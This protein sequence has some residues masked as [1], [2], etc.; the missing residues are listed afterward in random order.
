MEKLY[1][2]GSGEVVVVGDGRP[3]KM[4]DLGCQDLLVL[5]VLACSRFLLAEVQVEAVCLSVVLSVLIST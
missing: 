3:G 5:P 1:G 2:R 4:A